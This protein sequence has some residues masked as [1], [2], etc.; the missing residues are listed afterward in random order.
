V[1]GFI[2]GIKGLMKL[3]FVENY[4]LFEVCE[5]TDDVCGVDSVD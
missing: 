1:D 4:S 2:S 5:G 3:L